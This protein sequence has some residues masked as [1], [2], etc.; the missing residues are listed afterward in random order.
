[1]QLWTVGH[2]SSGI[3]AFLALLGA[4]GIGAVVDVRRFPASRRYPHFS[5]AALEQALATAGIGYLHVPELGGRR[6]PRP[7]SPNTGWRDAGF[8][9]YADYMETPGFLPALERL[10]AIAAGE[11][12]AM[13]CAEADWRHCHRGLIADALR[14]RGIEV[15][16]I[17]HAGD[18]EPH[19]F[20]EPAQIVD[21]RLSYA[22][23]PPR[24]HSLDL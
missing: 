15:L 20:T 2:S 5:R 12:T 23:R 22:L 18:A 10:I 13:M 19:A 3:D 16:H 4:H 21:G 6:E 17:R 24:Q 8:R 14:L 7:D 9:G 1:V 11:R